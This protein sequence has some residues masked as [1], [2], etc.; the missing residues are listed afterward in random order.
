M[1][2]SSPIE[3]LSKVGKVLFPTVL[4]S[5]SLYLLLCE[6]RTLEGIHAVSDL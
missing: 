3:Y 4:S 5:S 6:W 2:R 1:W